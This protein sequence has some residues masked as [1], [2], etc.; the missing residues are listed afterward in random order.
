LVH[1]WGRSQKA[2]QVWFIVCEGLG[3]QC[4]FGFLLG[5]VSSGRKGLFYSLGRFR[6]AVQARFFSEGSAG[7][8]WDTHSLGRSWEAVQ[9]HA[10]RGFFRSALQCVYIPVSYLKGAHLLLAVLASYLSLV[11]FSFYSSLW[12][13]YFSFQLSLKEIGSCLALAP[14]LHYLDSRGCGPLGLGCLSKQAVPMVII[15]PCL[16]ISF[17]SLL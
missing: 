9:W 11:G 15:I 4:R 10:L 16:S 12:G 7:L 17:L 2:V 8:V 3:R 1:C 13:S 6:E 5:K 14:N